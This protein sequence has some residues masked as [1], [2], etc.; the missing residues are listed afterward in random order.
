ME[1]EKGQVVE[2]YT[3]EALLGR[4]GMA[5]VY[6][7]RHNTLGSLHALKL[8]SLPSPT[9]C[10]RMMQEG[11]VQARLSHPNIVSV[12]D[13]VEVD[14]AQGLLMEYVDGPSL[15]RLLKEQ[16][17]TLDQADIFAQGIIEAV[18]AA[19][20][21]GLIHRDLKPANILV[22]ITPVGLR[23]KITDFGLAKI[24]AGDPEMAATRSGVSMGTPAFMSP[25]QVRDSKTVD[26]RAD[27]FALGA[28]LYELVTGKRAFLGEDV[29]EIFSAVTAGDFIHPG[30]HLQALPE[31][32]EKA[33]LGAL[34]VD[35]D[36]RIPN[37]LSLLA[38][39][40]GVESNST[41]VEQRGPWSGGI[42]ERATS[43]GSGGVT[44]SP[45]TDSSAQ[46]E[47]SEDT[48]EIDLDSG[49][50][51]SGFPPPEE[52]KPLSM[53]TT[54]LDF[55]SIIDEEPQPEGITPPEEA[56]PVDEEAQPEPEVKPPER[57]PNGRFPYVLVVP[58]VATV[59]LFAAV[60]INFWPEPAEVAD[61][62]L[63]ADTEPK[64]PAP[65]PKTLID[66]N[67]RPQI[68][69]SGVDRARLQN[70]NQGGFTKPGEVAPGTYR[71]LAYFDG[72]ATDVGQVSV[73][74]GERITYVCDPLRR[75][76]DRK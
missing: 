41:E 59:L 44:L 60:T 34:T 55:P 5:V 47:L 51:N 46:K 56:P 30:E 2:R 69:I 65:P 75:A 18:A 70:L 64:E 58:G 42:I 32:M 4:G 72:Q 24:L 23:P 28:V 50:L 10:E 12:T 11:R 14:G 3:V 73:E 71:V 25:E 15:D 19:H 68:I 53:E 33:I 36:E 48:F 35:L 7:V 17:L 39:W 67:A 13:V 76:C 21:F 16:P 37:C 57:R 52:K 31:R 9:I 74:M 54:E 49:D 26:E 62:D 63:V 27:V 20:D 43:L 40:R 38:A 29:F 6:R 8:L 45:A 1:L 66:P 61:T 22:A